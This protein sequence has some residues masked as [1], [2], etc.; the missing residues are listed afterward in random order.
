MNKAGQQN[1]NFSAKSVLIIDPV[2]NVRSI[3]AAMLRE[4]GFFHIEQ[5]SRLSVAKECIKNTAFDIIICEQQLPDTSGLVLLQEIRSNE[6]GKT[7]TFIIV[8]ASLDQNTVLDAVK[9]GV[10]EFIV[11]PFSL[12]MFK[13]RLERGISTPLKS[14]PGWLQNEQFQRQH[15]SE[16]LETT[17]ILVV[18]DVP[19]NIKI[20]SEVIRS[21]YQVKAATSGEKALKICLSKTPPDVV[22]LDI[23]MPEMDGL[24][25]CKKLKSNPLT[26]H[27]TVIFVSA[28]D[29]TKDVVKGLELGAVDYITKP[30]NPDI[31]KARVKNHVKIARATKALREQVD[32]MVDYAQL[33]SE[34]ERVVQQDMKRPIDSIS[35]TIKELDAHYDEPKRVLR[36]SQ[37]LK[38]VCSTANGYMQN[39]A[40]IQQFEGNSYQFN[41]VVVDLVK[42]V[43]EV[44]KQLQPMQSARN[45]KWTIPEGAMHMIHA[46]KN[47]V[48]TTLINLFK[49]AIEASQDGQGLLVDFKIQ[50]K[51]L[52]C[53]IH[54]QGVVPEQ[55]M[56]RFFDKYT[57]YGKPDGNGLGTYIAKLLTEAQQGNIW[58]TSEPAV[59]T[60]VFVEY[61]RAI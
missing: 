24:T 19:D 20:I 59:G 25:V 2:D 56:E 3:I 55:I 5:T 11:K 31:L 51:N 58:F 41:P 7:C 12:K 53:T 17:S 15:G 29:Q 61:Q 40:L 27:I 50:G 42:V 18:D 52:I 36:S 14:L 28:M 47:L 9:S 46:E 22:L 10:S 45:L 44:V 23:M 16:N 54:N 37:R 32:L 6:R 4:L 26:Q 39:Q 38:E 1:N 60:K 35:N 13:Q 57:G 8:S 21:D 48:K 43:H 30:V 49:N 33:R 34:F